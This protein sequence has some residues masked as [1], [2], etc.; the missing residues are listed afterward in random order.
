M[1]YILL[2]IL[3][4]TNS[5]GIKELS[6]N[7]SLE[8][9]ADV[10]DI[11]Y[12]KNSLYVATSMGKVDIFNIEKKEK[13]SIIEIP[14]IKDFIGDEIAAKI[15]SIDK[16]TNKLLIVSQGSKGYRNLWIY[17]GNKL[18][19]EIDISK[20]LYIRK[21]KFLDE[22]RVIL[23]LLSNEFVLYD[24]QK[25]TIERVKQITHSAFSDFTLSEDKQ[26]IISTDESGIVRFLDSKTFE[27]QKQLK[28]VNLDKV[29]QVAYKK[30]TVLTAGQDRKSALYK[31]NKIEEFNFD[32]LVYSCALS[33][34]ALLGAIAYDEN[35]DVL[36][37]D[38]KNNNKLYS[39]VGNKAVITKI[40]FIND[41]E[42][43]VSSESNK[44]NFWRLP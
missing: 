11:Y 21:A 31:E 39:L 20:K 24:L 7:Y 41:K 14:K 9:S 25:H 22:N 18:N 15:Y 26:R 2:I 4:I 1:K 28:A 27:E 34:N 8:A 36:I 38:I 3:L 13:T 44:I 40:V 19:K 10:Q 12:E 37:L 35:N 23:A 42:L 16:T 33:P 30:G 5:F 6:A 29:F 32:F 17:S 43:F